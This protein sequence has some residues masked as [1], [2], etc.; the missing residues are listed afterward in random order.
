MG[1]LGAIV[2]YVV[3]KTAWISD[4]AI[5]TFRYVSNLRH[6][7]GAVFNVGERV[8]GYTHP[9]W[10]ALLCVGS[11][12]TS[13]ETFAAMGLSLAFTFATIVCLGAFLAGAARTRTAGSLIAALFAVLLAT[14]D[15]WRAFQTSGLEGPLSSLL[16]VLFVVSVLDERAFRPWK[17]LLGGALLALCRPDFALLVTPAGF[18]ALMVAGRERRLREAAVA[19][20]PLSGFVFARVYYGEFL[21]NTGHAK[22]GI[23]T[24][25][26]GVH[27]GLLYVTDWF[28]NEPVTVLASGALLIFGA[29]RVRRRPEG[30]LCLGLV[31]YSVYLVV[32]GGDFMRG[33]LLM[34]ILVGYSAFGGLALA[35]H[36]DVAWTLPKSAAAA[37]MVAAVGALAV[38]T[39][40]EQTRMLS[41]SGIIN[42]RMYWL[43]EH[44]LATYAETR[45]LTH[46][47]EFDLVAAYI[48]A[49]G[50]VTIHSRTPAA[51][52]Y[53]L[54]PQL[55]VID[56]LGLTDRTIAL[57]PR[58]HLRAPPPRP[59]HP[60]KRIPI[61]YLA[62]RGDVSLFDDW[63]DKMRELDCSMRE[64]VR[65]FEND[66][67]LFK[68]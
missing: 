5:I 10:F 28:V 19:L 29:A 45:V 54:G 35:R 26:Q 38:T 63:Q 41:N 16:V 18:V 1:A 31:V 36:L 6:G 12:V 46:N 14:S 53:Y 8:Q 24:F 23:Y 42:E 66:P 67:G 33:R 39:A 37:A 4:D 57:L 2:T 25:E 21:P 64:R 56:T 34:P 44:S 7:Y 52:G 43:P 58:S 50:D 55:S 32:I 68:P 15:S 61:A 60:Y 20:L 27:Q 13:D 17:V 3:Y 9:L 65:A 59:G 48:K 11:V 51:L 62:R 30:A 22:L 47:P 40:P 49:C